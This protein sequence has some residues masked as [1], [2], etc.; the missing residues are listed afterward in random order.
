MLRKTPAIFAAAALLSACVT[1]PATQVSIAQKITASWAALDAAA[2][3][4]DILAKQRVLHGAAAATAAD[5]LTKA[6]ALLTAAD[7][8][9]HQSGTGGTAETNL[10]A[11]TVLISELVT[12]AAQAKAH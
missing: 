10:T 1:T 4:I 3:A 12:I 11:A 5:D 9:Y 6:T 7:A 2:N 8:A